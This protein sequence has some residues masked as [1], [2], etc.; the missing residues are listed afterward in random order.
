MAT[1]A[2]LGIG[3]LGAGFARNLLD[4]GHTVRVW[5]RTAAKA[6]A[7]A[8]DGAVVA[9]D[10]AEAVQGAERVHLLLSED[11]AVDAV[12]AAL[13]P[14]LGDAVPIVDHSTNLPDR[15][16]ERAARLAAEGVHY[17][18][19][20][21]FM[22]PANARDGTGLMLV[23][24]PSALV[25]SVR[26]SLE[27]MTGRV[28][29][30][31]ERPDLAAT[32]KLTGNGMLLVLTAGMGDL[33][34]LARA[35]GLSD[36]VVMELFAQFSPTPAGM[37]ARVLRAGT[38]PASFELTMGR[39]DCRLMIE[40]AGGADGLIVLPAIAEAMDAAIEAGLGA[41]DF[42]IFAKPTD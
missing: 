11:P 12:I 17:L 26:P 1:I 24:G 30:L 7:L 2:V 32:V 14:G 8:A 27:E 38:I 42:A 3:L 37:G 19:A 13:R 5:N 34:R 16:A 10:A 9:T 31:G 29:P 39:K 6:A 33:F 18:H 20:P 22:G 41:E 40:A 36:E 21:V 4:K 35:Q 28:M 23:S 25:E 15:V